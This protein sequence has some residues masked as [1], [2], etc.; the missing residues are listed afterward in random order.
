MKKGYFEQFLEQC[1]PRRRNERSRNSWMQEVTTGI[2]EKGITNME[3]VDREEWR[4]KL[5]LKLQAQEDV[6]TWGEI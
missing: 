4:S 2:G 6:Q 3:W 1:P 5:Q